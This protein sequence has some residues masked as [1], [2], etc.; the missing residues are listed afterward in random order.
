MD[1]LQTTTDTVKR[2]EHH[3]NL[4]RILAQHAG[5]TI[6]G[7]EVGDIE[8]TDELHTDLMAVDVEVH[9]GE[10]HLY[11]ACAE[12]GHL[13]DRISFD[14]SLRVLNHDHAVLVIGIRDGEG[15]LGQP[16]EESLLR[17]A[18][19]LESLMIV[20]MVARE[21]GEDASGKLQSADALLMDGM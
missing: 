17:V 4:F 20:Q 5:G 12:V 18:I 1:R 2:A 13:T 19:V 11:D 16:V 9:T 6:D 15:R 21:I 14:R 10:V 7:E 8:L 3:E